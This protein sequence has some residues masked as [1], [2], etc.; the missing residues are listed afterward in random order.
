MHHLTPLLTLKMKPKLLPYFR[1]PRQSNPANPSTLPIS[2]FTQSGHPAHLCSS[3][4]LLSFLALSLHGNSF[5][6]DCPP[7]PRIFEWLPFSHPLCLGS[8]DQSPARAATRHCLSHSHLLHS[9]YPGLKL[10]YSSVYILT[11]YHPYGI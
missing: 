3:N 6:S 8:E 7:P 10:F 2:L 5:C 4:R 11:I 1:G 9:I